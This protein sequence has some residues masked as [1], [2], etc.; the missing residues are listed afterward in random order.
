MNVAFVESTLL[1]GVL[2]VINCMFMDPTW[3]MLCIAGLEKKFRAE[4]INTTCYLVNRS[5]TTTLSCQY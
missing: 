4:A 2:E 1:N 3:S 5:S